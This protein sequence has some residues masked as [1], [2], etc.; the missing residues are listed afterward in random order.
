[1]GIL[2]CTPW[3]C[4]PAD[5]KMENRSNIGD[6]NSIVENTFPLNSNI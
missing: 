3:Q 2:T 6:F 1:M 5:K 4:D